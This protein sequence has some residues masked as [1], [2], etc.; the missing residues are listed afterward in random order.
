MNNV[1]SINNKH[2]NQK[3]QNRSSHCWNS[4]L[5]KQ[6]RKRKASLIKPFEWKI[7]ELKTCRQWSK[8]VLALNQHKNH[9]YIINRKLEIRNNQPQDFSRGTASRA[10]ASQDQHAATHDLAPKNYEEQERPRIAPSTHHARCRTVIWRKK[11][12]SIKRDH[13]TSYVPEVLVVLW[14]RHRGS[15]WTWRHHWTSALI[16]AETKTLEAHSVTA[17]VEL[18]YGWVEE[19]GTKDWTTHKGR[20]ADKE[21]VNKGWKAIKDGK[22][23]WN[24]GW[25]ATK[26][27]TKHW[28]KGWKMIKDETK[29]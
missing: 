4:Q 13:L 7:N 21:D 5:N 28:N 25:K 15:L 2:T 17:P 27:K 9:E 22:M 14:E 8:H 26:D 11:I 23:H 6:N 18:V 10:R 16:A 19:D 29:H 1:P 3:N 20:T 12:N 24:E